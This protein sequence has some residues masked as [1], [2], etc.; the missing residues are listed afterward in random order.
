MIVNFIKNLINPNKK[1][2]PVPSIKSPITD[3]KMKYTSEISLNITYLRNTDD[4]ELES[5]YRSFCTVEAN[6]IETFE[7]QEQEVLNR[8]SDIIKTIFENLEDKSKNYILIN[9]SLLIPK[10]SFVSANITFK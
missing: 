3:K 6:E 7:E 4:G 5:T 8:N 9:N 1:F 2:T 10:S